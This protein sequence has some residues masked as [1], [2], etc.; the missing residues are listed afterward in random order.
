MDRKLER[1]GHIAGRLRQ[2]P[3]NAAPLASVCPPPTPQ[4]CCH[5]RHL[6]TV[7]ARR[8]QRLSRG[9]THSQ[10]SPTFSSSYCVL[11]AANIARS[12]QTQLQL[13]PAEALETQCG[14]TN[15][16]YPTNGRFRRSCFRHQAKQQRQARTARRSCRRK[17][18]SAP[19]LSLV[20]RPSLLSSYI[21]PLSLPSSH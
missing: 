17:G 6:G 21:I 3:S 12:G 1:W 10:T 19:R 5:H 20:P 16:D 8:K 4:F 13:A 15:L 18:S 7:R 11:L 2:V 14:Q 9:R